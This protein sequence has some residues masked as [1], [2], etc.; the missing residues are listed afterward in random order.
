MAVQKL[1]CTELHHRARERAW[2]P[3][4]DRVLILTELSLLRDE[5]PEYDTL[6]ERLAESIAEHQ[7]AG[8]TL[9]LRS[10]PVLHVIGAHHPQADAREKLEAFVG[11]PF[12][13]LE[14]VES[15]V[16]DTGRARLLRL[17]PEDFVSRPQ[18]IAYM[19]A[20]GVKYAAIVALRARDRVT[21]L[22][23]LSSCDVLDEDD[24][25]FLDEVAGRIG[26]LVEYMR[27]STGDVAPEGRPP[28]AG[29]AAML[30]E[31]E[32][33]V[34]GLLA[35]GMTSREVAERLVLSVRTVEW[36]RGRMQTKLGVSGR[37]GLTRVAR[38]AG[39]VPQ[40][41]P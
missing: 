37:S 15:T 1:G 9:S 7:G 32:R 41:V 13:I 33:D 39:L 28:L 5:V 18:D 10:G 12:P 22:L 26:L 6:L 29:P 4:P 3:T 21:G 24:L 38:E 17:R 35:L 31:R 14:G 40:D 8:C 36:H 19:E 20:S 34:L 16:L 30:T 27:L 25:R 23:W 11:C 2:K